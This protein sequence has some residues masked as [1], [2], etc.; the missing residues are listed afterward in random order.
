M[1]NCV[2]LNDLVRGFLYFLNYRLS[3]DFAESKILCILSYLNTVLDI[4][5]HEIR[6]YCLIYS[7]MSRFWMRNVRFS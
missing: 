2:I 1:Y 4:H 6:D 5:I 3:F 7:V